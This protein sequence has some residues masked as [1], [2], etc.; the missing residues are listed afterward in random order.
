VDAEVVAAAYAF[1]AIPARYALE[2]RRWSEAARLELHPA[3]FPWD[4]FRYAEAIT[5]FARAIGAARSGNP[6]GA[7]KDVEKLSAIQNTLTEA[8]DSYWAN[9]VEIQRRG[10]AAW[11]AHAEGKHDEALA[12]MRSAAD[13][14][15]STEKHPVTP[16]PIIPA[17]ELLGDMLTEMDQPAQALREFE[18]SLQNSPN[19]FN[20]LY[21]AARAAQL[22]G[23]RKKARAYYA[24]IVRV[25]AHADSARTE[26]Q[27]A[28]EIVA[29]R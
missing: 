2:R 7:R 29:K 4:H 18:T 9:Q 27:K 26:L 16:G 13:L 19:R 28:R 14:E 12:L 25:S 11:L 5:Y 15:A 10:A 20:G 3:A 24:K 22:A 23:D 1:A 17:R 8:K 6:D 21:G